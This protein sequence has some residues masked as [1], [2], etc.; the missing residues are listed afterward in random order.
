[1]TIT[2]GRVT[3]SGFYRP[4][5]CGASSC[6]NFDGPDVVGKIT[7]RIAWTTTGPAI[8]P[9]VVVYK[10]NPAT[11]SGAPTDT[12]TLQAP[13][14]SATK[15]GSFV[16]PSTSNTTEIK[17][18]VPAPPCGGSPFSSFKISGGRVLV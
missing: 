5:A 13:P 8:A 9:T 4:L 17:T 15:A 10:N 18:D 3:G 6:A 11:A 2:G 1:V 12:I 7:V 14:G 16:V